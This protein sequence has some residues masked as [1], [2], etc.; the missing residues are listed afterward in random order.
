LN[1]EWVRGMHSC[2]SERLYLKCFGIAQ[3]KAI[4][5]HETIHGGD[6]VPVL[7]GKSTD[8]RMGYA[9]DVIALGYEGIVTL[10]PIPCSFTTSDVDI[11]CT[12]GVRLI[13]PVNRPR[14]GGVKRLLRQLQ[15]LIGQTCCSACA[16][17]T[18]PSGIDS[19]CG[20]YIF[21]DGTLVA[22]LQC[23]GI[24]IATKVECFGIG[25]LAGG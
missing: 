24:A 20:I 7:H 17:G 14:L 10:N 23:L 15:I 11:G 12:N 19:N 2:A 5:F 21:T 18:K 6:V 8:A 1:I 13:N 16:I 4:T 25:I 9:T 3:C 22:H